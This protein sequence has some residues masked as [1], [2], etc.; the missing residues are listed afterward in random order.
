M[1]VVRWANFSEKQR[2]GETILLAG[3]GENAAAGWIQWG[4]RNSTPMSVII[5]IFASAYGQRRSPL[6]SKADV[7]NV[8]HV[9]FSDTDPEIHTY[10]ITKK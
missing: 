7:L 10:F 8:N 6:N 1:S 5:F 4:S 9:C 3:S 2:L